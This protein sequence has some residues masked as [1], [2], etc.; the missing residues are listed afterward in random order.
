MVSLFANLLVF[1]VYI[2]LVNALKK[3]EPFSMW[4]NACT[5]KS[6]PL[7]LRVYMI[8]FFSHFALIVVI[9]GTAHL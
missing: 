9:M 6:I 8:Y 7:F 4:T 3:G 1:P 2:I 5:D